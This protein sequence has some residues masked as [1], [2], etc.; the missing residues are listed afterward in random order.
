[1]RQTEK[2]AKALKQPAPK[3]SPAPKP[4]ALET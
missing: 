1:V 3:P 2:L 4:E